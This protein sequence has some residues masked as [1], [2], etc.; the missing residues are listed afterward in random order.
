M[1]RILV[2]GYSCDDKALLVHLFELCKALKGFSIGFEFKEP[3]FDL[4]EQIA[5]Y[6]KK[7][8]RIEELAQRWFELSFEQLFDDPTDILKADTDEKEQ[9]IFKALARQAKAILFQG[10]IMEALRDN[11]MVDFY[12]INKQSLELIKEH[13]NNIDDTDIAML[14]EKSHLLMIREE[15]KTT[16]AA[17]ETFFLT[18]AGYALPEAL[19][20]TL[21]QMQIPVYPVSLQKDHER[22]IPFLIQKALVNLRHKVRLSASVKATR[23]GT[24]SAIVAGELS[25]KSHKVDPDFAKKIQS[26]TGDLFSHMSSE[27]PTITGT[28]HSAQNQEDE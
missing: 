9:K 14:T 22:S 7:I 12:G 21:H 10:A 19:K 1:Q 25:E 5:L 18:S 13:L 2:V 11:D 16:R 20:K 24:S 26:A 27:R 23:G 17:I 3:E 4:S 28:E 8:R 6:Q 15:L